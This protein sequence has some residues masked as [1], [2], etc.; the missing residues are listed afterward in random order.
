MKF[1]RFGR[2]AVRV[3]AIDD[4]AGWA[5]RIRPI[6]GGDVED[7]VP[8]AVDVVVIARP[9]RFEHVAGRMID[10]TADWSDDA[11]TPV[12]DGRT[13]SV[14]RPV[15]DITIEVDVDGPDLAD[16]A[17]RTGLSVDEVR[18]RVL[19]VP[20]RSAFCG[21]S[22]GFAY[23]TGLPPELHLER[24]ASPR[25]AVP[26]GSLAIAAGYA[27]VYPTSSPGGWHLIGSTDV[28][29]WDADRDPPALLAPGTLVRF[30]QR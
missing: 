13:G 27:A 17:E 23:L 18:R 14:H 1:E 30:T 22:P 5:R 6:V 9:G 28:A 2:D 16:V 24:R 29:V 15:A 10:A 12:A 8:G 21:F 19:D 7:V 26:A 20:L 4:P 11:A 3:S 25:R